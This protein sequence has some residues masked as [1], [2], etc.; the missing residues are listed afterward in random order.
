MSTSLH[1][2]RVVVIGG[3][4]GIGLAVAQATVQAGAQVV[5]ASRS[6]EKVRRAAESIGSEA[7]GFALDVTSEPEVV[8]FFAAIGRFDHLVMSVGEVITVAPFLETSVSNAKRVFEIKFWG[9]YLCALYGAPSINEGGSIVLTSGVSSHKPA[10]G[11]STL[12]G[13]DGALE[14]LCRSL[15][16][17][18]APLRVNTVSPGLVV[19]DTWNN[20]SEDERKELYQSSERT[21]LVGRVAVPSDIAGSYLHLMTSNY[22]TGHILTVDGG[23]S[24]V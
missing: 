23:Y 8:Q 1:G 4:S 12:A 20:F 11:D 2:Q 19:T 3:S 16:R 21:L 18:L 7:Q 6:A 14:S 10:G 13:I 24:V 22:T 17:E 15:A 5:V 9:Q